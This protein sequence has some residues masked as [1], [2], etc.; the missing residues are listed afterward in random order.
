MLVSEIQQLKIRPEFSFSCLL[1]KLS[2]LS[3]QKPDSLN[4]S[5]LLLGCFSAA[6]ESRGQQQVK[7]STTNTSIDLSL[8]RPER[9]LRKAPFC[10]LSLLLL[11][12]LQ[13][14]LPGEEANKRQVVGAIS[15]LRWR[16]TRQLSAIGEQQ[17]SQQHSN[18]PYKTCKYSSSS[19]PIS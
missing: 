1:W 8:R 4:G 17:S 12:L 6:N 19:S 5:N 13:V 3:G 14:H 2:A 9:R 18:V 7:H 16:S 11:I 10:R 15:S